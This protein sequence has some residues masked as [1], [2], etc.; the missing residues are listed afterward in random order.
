MSKVSKR[1]K[2][3]LSPF[4]IFAVFSLASS[5]LASAQQKTG[6]EEHENEASVSQA[7]ATMASLF[8][9]GAKMTAIPRI[10]GT[11]AL[12]TFDNPKMTVDEEVLRAAQRQKPE[13]ED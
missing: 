11:I 10:S 13:T 1:S 9:R 5:P 2:S 8:G 6:S 4:L 12:P 3:N 7:Q